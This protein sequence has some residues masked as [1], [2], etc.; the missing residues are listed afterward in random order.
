MRKH[1]HKSATSYEGWR[2]E[3]ERRDIDQNSEPNREA[4]T[5][6]MKHAHL[7]SCHG[8]PFPSE[9][10]ASPPSQLAASSTP[11]IQSQSQTRLSDPNRSLGIAKPT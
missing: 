11:L 10:Y 3:E 6:Q 8:A 7:Y 9:F 5:L 4:H 1:H 2:L